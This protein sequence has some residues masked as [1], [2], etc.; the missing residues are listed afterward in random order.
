[1]DFITLGDDWRPKEL[2]EG[3]ESLI[4]T[5]R[6]RTAGDFSLKT[7]LIDD[8]LRAMP[9]GSCVSLNDTREVCIVENM[10]IQRD[11][12]GADVLTVT[13]RS[14]ETFLENRVAL[15]TLT[16]ITDTSVT[17]NE[18]NSLEINGR[19]AGSAA[20][21]LIDLARGTTI[22]ANDE[23]PN[24]NA[25]VEPTADD[26]D[27]P[28]DR[29][30]ARG[31]V[32][33][34]LLKIL[35]EGNLGVRNLR[36]LYNNTATLTT[37]V[38]KWY[39]LVNFLPDVAL[40]VLSGHFVGPVKYAWSIKGM[41]TAAYVASKNGAV[42]YFDTGAS[43]YKG[44]QHRVDLVDFSDITKAASSSLNSKL[45]AKGKS[46]VNKH[47][48]LYGIDGKVSPDIPYK[49]N[50]DYGLGDRFKV[51][52]DYGAEDTVQVVEFIRSQAKDGGETGYPTYIT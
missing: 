7:A 16:K 31:S 23:I 15:K 45:K 44:M 19:S 49:Y 40:D 11:A 21:Y 38:Y 5:E 28:G 24:Y 18:T 35:D 42:K 51:R 36:P 2:V 41:K 26:V 10:E 34:E 8:A 39:S 20:A 50:V 33:P 30:I 52:G 32:Y 4:W 13:G 17:P 1:M 29:E 14:W 46:Y 6:W 47:K 43:G 22:S 27:D 9:L 48:K 25:T 3:W 12:K 37:N